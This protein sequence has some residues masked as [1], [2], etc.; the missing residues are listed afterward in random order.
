MSKDRTYADGPNFGAG[1]FAPEC[2]EEGVDDGQTDGLS[3]VKHP[4]PALADGGKGLGDGL[5]DA[6]LWRA[7]GRHHLVLNVCWQGVPVEEIGQQHVESLCSVLVGD[8]SRIGQLPAK[9]VADH[10][11]DLVALAARDITRQAGDGLDLARCLALVQGARR[12][13]F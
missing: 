3:V 5:P 13:A 8:E 1:H 12:A 10:H 11:D 6:A 7:L 9:D 2:R 4:G